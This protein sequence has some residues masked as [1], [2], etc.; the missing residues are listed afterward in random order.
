[1]KRTQQKINS[2]ESA[3]L[4]ASY[5]RTL[6]EVLSAVILSRDCSPLLLEGIVDFTAD[7]LHDWH[8]NMCNWV[9]G[10]TA[11]GNDTEAR[12][13]QENLLNC[14]GG[15]EMFFK[16][17]RILRDESSPSPSRTNRQLAVLREI[18]GVGSNS[19]SAPAARTK[20]QVERTV[21]Q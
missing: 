14:L 21:T 18:C 2:A 19:R 16:L 5:Y 3:A 8:E 13:V 10:V 9:E 17:M 15:V 7:D 6:G 12:L 1:M 11:E 4:I 20:R